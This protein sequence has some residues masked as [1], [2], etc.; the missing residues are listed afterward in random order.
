MATPL[1]TLLDPEGGPLPSDV[2][3]GVVEIPLEAELDDT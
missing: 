3:P 1:T 2:A